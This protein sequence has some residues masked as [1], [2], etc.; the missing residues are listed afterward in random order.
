M[1]MKKKLLRVYNVEMAKIYGEKGAMV[2]QQIDYWMKKA[3]GRHIDGV[4][5][6]Y[7]TYVQLNEQFP[8][9]SLRTVKRVVAS[10]REKGVIET[11]KEY[12]LIKGSNWVKLIPVLK[13]DEVASRRIT[14]PW[15]K[16]LIDQRLT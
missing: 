6:I 7:M 4:K 2:L 14:L 8:H 11:K 10:L 15:Q 13:R 3:K 1:K 5:W 9:W 16:Y 12:E